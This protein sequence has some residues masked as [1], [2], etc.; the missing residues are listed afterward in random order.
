MI[1]GVPGSTWESKITYN[2]HPLGALSEAM[3][4]GD[5]MHNLINRELVP[6][7]DKPVD[8]VGLAMPRR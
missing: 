3:A 7:P 5:N 6:P 1:T 2:I 4:R 8:L